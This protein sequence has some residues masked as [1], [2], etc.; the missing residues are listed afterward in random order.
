MLRLEYFQFLFHIDLLDKDYVRL[1]PI[2]VAI[3]LSEARVIIKLAA[4]FLDHLEFEQAC[5]GTARRTTKFF[6]ILEER[7]RTIAIK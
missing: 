4:K 5:R 2:D 1:W 3:T 7:L 6:L